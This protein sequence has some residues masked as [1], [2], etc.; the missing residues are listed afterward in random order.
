MTPTA[1]NASFFAEPVSIGELKLRP[2]SL[3]QYMFLQ[4]MRS[5][6]LSEQRADE[7]DVARSLVV[8]TRPIAETWR[9]WYDCEGAFPVLALPA[10]SEDA[11]VP[12]SAFDCEAWSLADK[13]GL[14]DLVTLGE[15]LK[16]LIDKEFSTAVPMRAPDGKE[17]SRPL[18]Q[19]DTQKVSAGN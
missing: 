11:P 19:A 4:F 15:V 14:G 2:F 12:A 5:P 7:I 13:I 17:G 18:G 6:I 16:T 8:M 3:A 9:L 10:P 1:V